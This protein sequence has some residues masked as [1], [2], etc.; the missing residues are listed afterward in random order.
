M[1]DERLVMQVVLEHI[2]FLLVKP[3]STDLL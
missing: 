1:N 2:Q 3:R